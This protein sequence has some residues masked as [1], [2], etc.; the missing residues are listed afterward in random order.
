MRVLVVH[1]RYRSAAPSGENNVVDQES[2]ALANRGHDVELFQRHSDDI[3]SWPIHRRAMIPATTIWNADSRRELATHLEAFRPDVVHIHNTF[4]LITPSA[5]YACRDAKVPVVVTLHNYKLLCPSGPFF[6]DGAPCHDCAGGRGLHAV[7]HGCYRGSRMASIPLVIG[8]NLHREA[9]RQLVSAYIFITAAQRDLMHD[10]ELPADRVFVKHNFVPSGP[11]VRR[12][13]DHAVAYVG[14]LD[15]AKGTP[16]LMRAW[17]MYRAVAPRSNLRLVIAGGGPL[18]DEVREWS[19]RSSSVDVL[20]LLPRQ[21]AADVV[22]KALAV[23]VPSRCEETFGL[24]AAEAMAA[25]VAVIA[26]ARGSLPELVEDGV[27]GAL[28]DPDDP[29]ALVRVFQQVD[30]EA[31]LFTAFGRAGRSAFEKRFDTDVI[32]DELLAIYAFAVSNRAG[33][34][35]RT[36]TP[37]GPSRDLPGIP[38]PQ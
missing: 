17:D 31:E 22:S 13:P 38:R 24:V 23:V 14:R 15:E 25:G 12:D 16:L 28:F 33:T 21:E 34:P 27:T 35:R 30:Q 36:P 8:H 4:P 1:S 26:S 20:G 5:L 18:A 7:Q 37:W 9:W 3:A 29:R 32:V 11:A 19:R 10:L 6:R 2:E